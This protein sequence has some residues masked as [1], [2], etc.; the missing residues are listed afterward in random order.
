MDGAGGRRQKTCWRGDTLTIT[1]D[2]SKEPGL[3]ASGKSTLIASTGRAVTVESGAR[4]NL[5][6]YRKT[7]SRE[8]EKRGERGERGSGSSPPSFKRKTNQENP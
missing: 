2:L 6:A 3:S 7:K 8:K 4:V 1:V 5:L